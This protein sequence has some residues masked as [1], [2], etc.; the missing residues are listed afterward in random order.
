MTVRCRGD[1]PRTVVM[2][3]SW[4][5]HLCGVTTFLSPWLAFFPGA[6]IFRELLEQS[7]V[8]ISH[9]TLDFVFKMDYFCIVQE[10]LEL[11]TWLRVACILSSPPA[12][13]FRVSGYR[14]AVIIPRLSEFFGQLSLFRILIGPVL[15]LFLGRSEVRTYI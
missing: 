7:R 6:L 1:S 5:L 10:G 3:L 12:S 8:C 14:H 15:W 9:H 4:N 11:N 2:R 13:D